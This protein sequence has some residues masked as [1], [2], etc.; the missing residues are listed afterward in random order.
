M[1]IQIFQI[2][3]LFHV[4]GNPAKTSAVANGLLMVSE[5]SREGTK[6]I[7]ISTYSFFGIYVENKIIMGILIFFQ[8]NYMFHHMLEILL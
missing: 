7:M 5:L 8:E 6:K 2:P 1:E 3:A 4:C